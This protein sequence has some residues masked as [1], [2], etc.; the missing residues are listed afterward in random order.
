MA[1]FGTIIDHGR[2]IFIDVLIDLGGN[3]SRVTCP[4]CGA[5]THCQFYTRTPCSSI[6]VLFHCLRQERLCSRVVFLLVCFFSIFL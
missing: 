5:R 2:G 1:K 6:R 3:H 4:H